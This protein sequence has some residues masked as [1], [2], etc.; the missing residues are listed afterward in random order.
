MNSEKKIKDK[1]GLILSTK[2]LQSSNIMSEEELF[3]LP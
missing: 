2:S 3:C 1:D